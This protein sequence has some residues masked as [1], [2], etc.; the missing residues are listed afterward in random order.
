[1]T[2]TIIILGSGTPVIDPEREGPTIAIELNDN[3]YLFDAGRGI[4]RR[5]VQAHL[6]LSKLKTL[7]LTHLH[8]DHTVG[9]PDLIFT[10]GVEGRVGL[11][12]Y[13]PRG[14]KKM[15]KHL[16]KA[17]KEDIKIRTKG[18]EEANLQAYNPHIM[19]IQTGYI[20]IDDCVQIEAFKVNHGNWP[21]FG[22][23]II[24][25]D[26]TIV[27]SGDT[28]PTELLIKK[29]KGC[30]IL[31]HEVYSFTGLLKRNKSKQ[32][33]HASMHT[34]SKELGVIAAKIKPKTLILY[35]QLYW[36]GNDE[37]IIS[38]IKENYNGV[39]ISAKDLDK[40]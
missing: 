27:I 20:F 25:P 15:I 38:D 8:S 22:Y 1:M 40:F 6:P 26:K 12:I 36:T 19:E 32:R 21:C 9:L 7:F 14:T 18:L 16:L 37:D 31:I 24:C 2:S 34:S 33:Y 10:A 17:Y 4:I 30:D 5:A 11:D 39:I 29:A 23:K 3:I 35:H 28:T 13:G